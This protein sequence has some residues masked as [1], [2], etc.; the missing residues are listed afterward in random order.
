MRAERAHL[1]WSGPVGEPWGVALALSGGEIRSAS[2][3][4]GVVQAL[5]NRGCFKAV[6]YLSTVSGGGYLGTALT[7]LRYRYGQ[8]FEQ[9]LGS[10]LRGDR[11][12]ELRRNPAQGAAQF[13]VSGAMARAAGAAIV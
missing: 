13:L 7:W 5:V 11:T 8:G 9:Q 2:F 6:D 12:E 1:G 4:L 10:G 3:A